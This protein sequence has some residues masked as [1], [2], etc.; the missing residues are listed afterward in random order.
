MVIVA[1]LEQPTWIPQVRP[2]EFLNMSYIANAPEPVR[3]DPLQADAEKLYS[4]KVVAKMA[5]NP[6]RC[7]RPGVERVGA[8]GCE[9]RV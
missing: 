4:E 6:D 9:G 7:D 5:D 3:L 2:I 8:H 1:L